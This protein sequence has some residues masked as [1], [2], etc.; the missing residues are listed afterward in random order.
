MRVL[1]VIQQS[2]QNHGTAFHLPL[3]PQPALWHK[4]QLPRSTRFF[5]D[6]ISGKMD[7]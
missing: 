3:L 7:L 1:K 6:L 2:L 4:N 5:P